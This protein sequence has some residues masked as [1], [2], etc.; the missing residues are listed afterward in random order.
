MTIMKKIFRFMMAALAATAA[1][2]ACQQENLE[3]DV[4]EQ[5]TV[6][7]KVTIGEQTKGFTDL[8]GIT[9]EVG[10]QIKYAGGVELTSEPL[11]AEKISAD[12]YTASFTFAASLNEVDRTGWFVS[13]KC[14]PRNSDEVDFTKVAAADNKYSITQEE[15]GVMNNDYLFLHSGTGLVSIAK[16]EAPEITMDIAGSIFRLIPYTNKYNT[17]SVVSVKMVSNTPFLGTVVYDRGGS[18]YTDAATK[19]YFAAASLAVKLGS[20]LSLEEVTSA[21]TSKGIYMAIAAT[22]D[23]KPLD[24]YQYIVETDKATYTFDAMDEELVVGENVVRNVLLN[25]DNASR[26]AESGALRYVGGITAE[27]NFGFDQVVDSDAG[28]WYAETQPSGEETWTKRVNAENAAY[29]NSVVFTASDAE[30]GDPVSWVRVTYGGNEGCHWLVNADAN[31]GEARSAVVTATFADVKGYV[32]I[33]ECRT[34]S[35]IVSQSASGSIREYT[36]GAVGNIDLS[37]TADAY[38]DWYAPDSYYC[39]SIGGQ[40]IESWA[41]DKN[42][43]QAL[44]S[45]VTMTPYV[46]GTPI[47]GGEVASWITIDYQKENGKI[48]GTHPIISVAANPSSAER[49][50]L[51]YINVTEDVPEG[52][53]WKGSYKQFMITQAGRQ[54]ELSAEL[55]MTYVGT[56][57]AS[58][59]EI[60]LGTLALTVDGDTAADVAAAMTQYGVTVTANNGAT[61]EVAADGTVTMDVPANPYA[62]GGKEYTVTVKHD[63]N[64][65]ATAT[66]NQAEG[67]DEG[68]EELT[69]PYTYDLYGNREWSTG[70]G[71]GANLSHTGHWGRIENVKLNGENVTLTAEIAEEVVTFALRSTAPTQEERDSVNSGL[72]DRTYSETAVVAKADVDFL[73]TVPNV[74]YITFATG[75]AWSSSKVTGYDSDGNE[76]GYWIVWTD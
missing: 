70:W 12:G 30:T 4:Q 17:E 24:G 10:D 74:I 13:T 40:N 28:Y 72:G 49:K 75:E 54:I 3:P 69:C 2:T 6:E 25:L 73:A 36:W 61:V 8:E 7:V 26:F 65:L 33:E 63:G 27:L 67:E 23:E 11:T 20:E 1:M 57:P 39:L 47:P 44:Y 52:Y 41:D 42:N 43:E 60:T 66:V 21:E 58:G 51:V 32:V 22:S 14:C 46:L 76:L 64:T 31:E 35:I 48:V 38:T 45:T 34:K 56:V 19:N 5:E 55:N 18:K 68:G 53:E 9:W 29:Y 16:D 15:A 71:F 62:N 59:D 50:A 37:F